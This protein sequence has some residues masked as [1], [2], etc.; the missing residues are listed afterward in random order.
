MAILRIL[1]IKLIELA[2]LGKKGFF[3]ASEQIKK[4]FSKQKL[5]SKLINVMQTL[6]RDGK[7][8]LS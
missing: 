3:F 1:K 6:E 8:V 7:H 2:N 5:P 4:K